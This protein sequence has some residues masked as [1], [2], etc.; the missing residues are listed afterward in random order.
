MCLTLLTSA[1]PP[2][3]GKGQT[4]KGQLKFT[5]NPLF[6]GRP[7]DRVNLYST[8]RWPLDSRLVI[9]VSWQTQTVQLKDAQET[10]W[11]LIHS[12]MRWCC[13]DCNSQEVFLKPGWLHELQIRD[14][15]FGVVKVLFFAD[16]H[17]DLGRIQAQ[18]VLLAY[19][20]IQVL[21]LN[22]GQW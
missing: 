1:R 22:R 6:A 20:R 15:K 8:A 21:K 9:C 4:N 10:G 17:L 11:M 14:C 3:T 5:H 16:G 19:S 2:V 18:L 7:V 12:F 13:G